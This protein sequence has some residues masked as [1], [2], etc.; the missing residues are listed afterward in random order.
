MTSKPVEV[1]TST[2][3]TDVSPPS[4]AIVKTIAA[5]ENVRVEELPPL[6]D[7]VCPESLDALVRSGNSS[8]EITFSIMTYTVSV[9]GSGLVSIA[10]AR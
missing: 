9:A 10:P 8:L 3:Y 1:T 5:L 2:T 7:F 4:Y 6:Y